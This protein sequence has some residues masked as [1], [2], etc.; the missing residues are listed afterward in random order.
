MG[1]VLASL[2]IIVGIWRTVSLI[3]ASRQPV[4]AWFVLGGSI[5]REMYIAE[6]A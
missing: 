2:I 6:Q 3:T 4:D 5:K 1:L